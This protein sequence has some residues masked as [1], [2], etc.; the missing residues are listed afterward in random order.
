MR[1][2]IMQPYFMP[3][4]GYW[5]LMQHVDVYVIYDNIQ[6]TRKGWI[7]R[8]RMLQNGKDEYFSLPLKKDSDYLNIDQRFLSD[9]ADKELLKLTRKIESNYR[10]AP[11]FKEHMPLVNDIFACDKTNLFDFL[12]YSI[13]KVKETLEINTKLVISSDLEIDHGLKSQE[14]VLAIC[15]ELG[16]TEYINPIGGL[17]LYDHQAFAESSIELKFM[18]SKLEAYPQFKNAFIPGLSILDILMFNEK[19]SIS[20][21]LN[22]NFELITNG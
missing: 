20:E 16:A 10:K 21:M 4:L 2:G 22:N 6:F 8:N 19:K 15:N 5:Q 1:V 7:H 3:Y 9:S 18:K 12:L 14:K 11:M 13:N 17:E